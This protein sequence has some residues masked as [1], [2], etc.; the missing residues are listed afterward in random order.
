M[1]R[2][3]TEGIVDRFFSSAKVEMI[4]N[5]ETE[6]RCLCRRCKL[7]CLLDP[8]SKTIKGHLLA[9]GFM[10]D[11]RWQGDEEDYEFVH[12]GRASVRR[13]SA[14]AGQED[15]EYPGHDLSQPQVR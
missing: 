3:M 14:E 4:Q 5:N 10:D 1:V 6:I 15:E 2:K 8:D 12:D 9:R 7:K 13:N 11:Y